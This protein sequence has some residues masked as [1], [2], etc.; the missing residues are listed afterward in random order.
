[1]KFH[2]KNPDNSLLHPVPRKI[3]RNRIGWQSTNISFSGTDI[4]NCY[5]FS[6]LQET[7]KP[8]AEILR[9]EYPASSPNII[10]S[11]SLKLY[12]NSFNM[13]KFGDNETALSVVN[14]DL[15]EKLVTADLSLYTIKSEN[16][17][18][19]FT[20]SAQFKY[21]DNL[22]I[23]D[24]IDYEYNPDLLKTEA[25]KSNEYFFKTNLMKS[26]CPLTGQPDWATVY[27]YYKAKKKLNPTSFLSYIIS[28][29][30]L[31]E[32]HEECC[33]RILYDLLGILQPE[34]LIVFCKY[35][36]RGGIDI[37]PLRSYP[38]KENYLDNLPQAFKK[39]IYTRDFRQ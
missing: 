18:G 31:G 4:W 21:L 33:E 30:T 36:R 26:N 25:A 1:M 10:E 37:N 9:I 38:V 35:T 2:I 20:D 22:H 6:F 17:S 39:I 12:L 7:G 24:K 23:N 28:Y 34:K 11:K 29:R 16:F 5:E 8:V 19:E 13:V 15:T 32:Y 3:G 14:K 27:L